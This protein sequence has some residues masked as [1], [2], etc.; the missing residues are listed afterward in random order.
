MEQQEDKI[1]EEAKQEVV[2]EEPTPQTE[3]G[4]V[5]DDKDKKEDKQ[6]SKKDRKK[7]C[8]KHSEAEEKVQELGEKLAE[9]NDKYLRIYSEYENYRKRTNAEKADLILNGGKDVIKAILPVLDD[10]ERALSTMGEDDS[11]RQGVQLILNKLQQI[12]QQKGLKAID[13]KGAKFDENLHEAV[14]QFPAAE[15]SQKGTVI[16][17]VEKGY[18]LNDKVLRYAKV[19]VAI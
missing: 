13:A 3:N 7:K 1:K 19:V 8:D 10:L 14:T 17:V 9:V 4:A 16:D 12:L 18:F 2:Q 6:E 15:E 11:H 5:A